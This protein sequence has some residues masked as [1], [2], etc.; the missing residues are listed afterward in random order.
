M[1]SFQINSPQ[2]WS[3]DHIKLNNQKHTLINPISEEQPELERYLSQYFRNNKKAYSV[4]GEW[5]DVYSIVD[6][7]QLYS[8]FYRQNVGIR[9]V[10][11]TNMIAAIEHYCRTHR[12]Y[13]KVVSPLLD[14]GGHKYM[15][16]LSKGFEKKSDSKIGFLFNNYPEEIVKNLK[17]DDV[18]LYST[19]ENNTADA[20][21]YLVS[22]AS[23]L[24][25][26]NPK[27][28]RLLDGMACIGGNAISFGKTFPNTIAN[29]LDKT[30]YEMM[31]H[32]LGVMGLKGV[33]TTN[34]DIL[35]HKELDNTE[36]LFLDPE[37]TGEDYKLVD[38]LRLKIG[39]KD[40][41]DFCRECLDRKNIKVLALKLPQNASLDIIVK[42]GILLE[43]LNMKAMKLGNMQ[44]WIY[45]K[46][47]KNAD[48]TQTSYVTDINRTDAIL[49]G[50]RG[51]EMDGSIIV[52]VSSEP[53]SLQISTICLLSNMFSESY[54]WSANNAY[55]VGKGYFGF[56]EDLIKRLK[57]VK[58]GDQ[59]YEESDSNW[60]EITSRLNGIFEQINTDDSKA[61]LNKI[62]KYILKY[63][64][65]KLD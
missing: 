20:I 8:A 7:Y 54:I 5:L 2:K 27:K 58:P 47:A 22:Q 62:D 34:D 33:K 15:Y 61:L 13:N 37:W 63:N 1:T 42:E 29:E 39:E 41:A 45:I 26:L 3:L 12:I 11:S 52:K 28:A 23:M 31:N 19:T 59:I 24:A 10:C 35:T 48:T 14:E 65:R 36:V 43:R 16:K 32:N 38:S 6:H 17:Y 50:L 25:G 21:T 56:M 30:R 60:G 40:L 46:M 57:S 49:N 9:M 44:L 51:L 4:N 53:T 18:S 64:I 55:F